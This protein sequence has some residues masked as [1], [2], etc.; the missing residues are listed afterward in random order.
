[1]KIKLHV[2]CAGKRNGTWPQVRK[3]DPDD[4]NP[5]RFPVARHGLQECAPRCKYRVVTYTRVSLCADP[6]KR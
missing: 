6:L 2:G 1:V 4:W 5:A 3:P